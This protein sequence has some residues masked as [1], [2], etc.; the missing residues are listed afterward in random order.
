MFIPVGGVAFWNFNSQGS[1]YN[2]REKVVKVLK[3]KI[4]KQKAQGP[5]RPANITLV[6]SLCTK[7]TM[8][9]IPYTLIQ[10]LYP[11][12]FHTYHWFVCFALL[13]AFFELRHLFGKVHSMTPMTLTFSRSIYIN[14]H[15]SIQARGP[16]FVHF[17]LRWAVFWLRPNFCPL[18]SM[19]SLFFSYGPIFGKV[20]QVT[21][22]CPRSN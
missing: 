19:M 10:S 9:S 1:C 8:V 4:V 18:R 16:I 2:Q 6:W 5:W 12:L 14:M 13:W 11:G 15:D 7:I 17:G 3:H 20:H 21:F 22:T